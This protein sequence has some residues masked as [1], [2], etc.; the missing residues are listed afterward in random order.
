MAVLAIAQRGAVK[1]F[2][3]AARSFQDG[4]SGA[5]IPFHCPSEAGIKVGLSFRHQTEFQG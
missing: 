2:D 1:G 4:L 5:D 3:G